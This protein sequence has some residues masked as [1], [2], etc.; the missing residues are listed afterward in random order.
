MA[1]G[2][3]VLLGAPDVS[4]MLGRTVA[5]L[6][7]TLSLILHEWAHLAVSH[8]YGRRVAVILL[9]P[10]G[11]G[12]AT[13]LSGENVSPK[14]EVRIAA[15][16]PLVSLLLGSTIV[17]A[18]EYLALD[19]I[20][21]WI[22]GAN[23]AVGLINL[24]PAFPLDGGYILRGLFRHRLSHLRATKWTNVV[25]RLVGFG[26]IFAGFTST[27]LWWLGFLGI[28]II[29]SS[30]TEELSSRFRTLVSGRTAADVMQHTMRVLPAAVRVI[31]ALEEARKTTQLLFPVCFG[32]KPLG[33]VSRSE[34]E[35]LVKE[36]LGELGISEHMRRDFL[37]SGRDEP[38]AVLL[39]RMANGQVPRAV[40]MEEGEPVGVV[41][42]EQVLREASL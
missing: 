21:L 23:L 29:L 27:Q 4:A 42:L 9:T 6:A 2:V 12:V 14:G 8:A 41:G 1:L 15:A 33:L 10:L 19:M 36:G 25:G 5:M 11:R 35:K 22:G 37:V 18:A 26:C 17:I 34:L 40:I 3:L 20:V 13:D 7:M 24:L 38:L 30:R 39:Q 31:D 16:G 28:F 32:T